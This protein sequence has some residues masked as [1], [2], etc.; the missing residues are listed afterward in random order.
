MLCGGCGA[1]ELKPLYRLFDTPAP[2]L[3]RFGKTTHRV[4]DFD[5][6]E[7]E[8]LTI[9]ERDYFDDKIGGYQPIEEKSL[10]VALAYSRRPNCGARDLRSTFT[11]KF[12]KSGAPRDG[13]E[14]YG[15]ETEKMQETGATHYGYVDRVIW[16]AQELDHYAEKITYGDA[17]DKEAKTLWALFTEKY[18]EWQKPASLTMLFNREDGS[19]RFIDYDDTRT[20]LL[21][22][23]DD[24]LFHIIFSTDQLR[25]CYM[26]A[27]GFNYCPQT[28][29][30]EGRPANGVDKDECKALVAIEAK[31]R[32]QETKEVYQF[33]RS[34]HALFSDEDLNKTGT[35][36]AVNG[37][38]YTR[39]GAMGIYD[40]R[41]ATIEARTPFYD[42][43]EP[44]LNEEQ[45]ITYRMQ[46]ICNGRTESDVIVFFDNL[47]PMKP[48]ASSSSNIATNKK[49]K[50]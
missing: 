47:E 10:L 38:T 18:L 13:S 41:W 39:A 27:R 11:G 5:E 23:H 9:V 45:L 22:D 35:V 34:L 44:M 19:L 15:D 25:T 3:S 17:E 43:E 33:N 42:E 37:K 6:N 29:Y 36:K 2:D 46:R 16:K 14:K 4:Y 31:M 50:N 24:Q 1:I 8:T 7:K 26:L 40:K 12:T 30:V 49:R 48:V 20:A 28:Q 32:N 21:D